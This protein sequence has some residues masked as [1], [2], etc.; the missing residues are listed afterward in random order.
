MQTV[1]KTLRGLINKHFILF[2]VITNLISYG[3]MLWM[4]PWQDDNA[5]FF[6]LA[7][8]DE[9]AGYF[10]PG[11][12]GNGLTKYAHTPFIPIYFL[13]GHNT[14]AYFTLLIILY[15]VSTLMVYK[16]FS[17]ILGETG[18]R[19]AGFLYGAGY[20]ISDGIWRMANSATT[21]LSIIFI[22]LFLVA[23]WQLYKK[24][25]PLWYALAFLGFFLSQE[26]T[27]V[28][29]HYFF[30]IVVLFELIFF[31]LRRFPLSLFFSILRLIPFF[32]IF[33]NWALAASSSRTGEARDFLSAFIEGKFHLYYG[34]L[35]SITNLVIPDWSTNH[36]FVAQRWVDSVAQ[37]HI[38]ILRLILLL[39]PGV[40]IFILLKKHKFGKILI[41][42]FLLINTFWVL[43]SKQ[44]FVS[45]LLSPSIEQS[46]IAT[47]GGSILLFS[48][49]IFF[50]LDKKRWIFLFLTLWLLINI[51]VYSAYNP[52]FQYGTVERYMA[53]SFVALVGIF[54]LLFISLPKR[55]LGSQVAKGSL[56]LLGIGNLFAAVF[57][58]NNILHTRSFPAREFY[59]N[60]KTL[61]PTLNKGTVLYFDISDN[62]QRYYNDAISTA[63]MPETTAFAWRYGI[64][65][66]DI[67]LTNN[68]DE[69]LKMVTADNIQRENIKGFWYSSDG[70]IDNS[71]QIKDF[72]NGT[73]KA[74][75][76]VSGL[77]KVSSTVL[78][79]GKLGAVW[80]QPDIEMIFDKPPVSVLPL[81][82]TLNITAQ[83]LGIG[84][85]YPLT[86]NKANLAAD[87]RQFWNDKKLRTLA[88]EYEK[89]KEDLVLKSKYRVSSEWQ[90]NVAK[91]LYDGDVESFWQSERT[92]WGREF[93]FIEVELPHVDKV[94]RIVWVNGF[95]SNTPVGY[96]IDVSVD[97]DKWQEVARV[98][99][100]A[101]VDNREPQVVSFPQVSARFVRM[102]LTE[103]L[104]GDSP[105]VAE[106]WVVPSKFSGLD[107][108]LAEQF[109]ENPFALVTDE[110]GFTDTLIGLWDKGEVQIF[111]E[112]NKKNGWQTTR[113]ARLEIYYNGKPRQ[114][115]FILPAGGTRI[116]K[117][118]ISNISVPGKMFLDGI[119]IGYPAANGFYLK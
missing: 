29:A 80:D 8:L 118:K 79:Q 68:F 43:I 75:F 62:M 115:K 107:I 22:N 103:T 101:K 112:S 73:V 52:T 98:N 36:L 104:N 32:F 41:P 116:S 86:W 7:H 90:K 106:F 84:Q 15:I 76:D 33:T 119:E 54:G 31:A 50:V 2:L 105:V 82:I 16:S 63:M 91:N 39:F 30:I 81:E 48:A 45:S 110:K 12:I 53:H 40:V 44:L 89:E 100:F 1:I 93:T 72:L 26:I 5:L 102:V 47:L 61:M 9:G 10:G 99:K 59:R 117:I 55:D 92:G 77:S 71:Q 17:L 74:R 34:F 94:D 38:P 23:Y 49:V 96:H 64:D 65:R 66:Y 27:I 19:I 67:K 56:V 109:L 28:R 88:L 69:L 78:T 57:Y 42:L 60:L 95:S 13:F 6:K 18:G 70:L 11:P 108:R 4:Y 14:V 25:N 114:Y 97:G 37:V 111:W 3:Q 83:P 85:G 87:Q 35:S 113:N 51:S 20:V 46:F 58:Q 21:S 24:G